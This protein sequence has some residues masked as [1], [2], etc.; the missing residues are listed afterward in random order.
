MNMCDVRG[1]ECPG[2]WFMPVVIVAEIF[3][4]INV[5]QT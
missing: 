3:Y 2:E 1:I 4:I 5:Q